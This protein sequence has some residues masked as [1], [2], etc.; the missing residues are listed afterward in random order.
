MM[1]VGIRKSAILLMS[2][3]EE[4]AGSVLRQLPHSAV[5]AM[6]E[7]MANLS[8]VKRDEV[9]AVLEEFRVETEQ[10]SALHLDSGSYLRAVLNKALGDDRA[11]DLLQDIAQSNASAGG[12][13]RLNQLDAKEVVEIIRDEHPQIIA[14]LLVHMDRLK[15]AEVLE[16]LP[17][18]VR[19]DAV[20]RVATFGGVQPSA[21]KELTEV[22]N[23]MLSGEGVK[24]G[25]LGG[26]RVAAEIV[27]LMTSTQEEGVIKHVREQD[28]VLAQKM[29]DEMFLFENLLELEDRSVQLLLKE[30]ESES[31]IIALKGAPV[32]L[33]EKFLKNM[34]QRA[35]ET[36]R[37]DIEARGPVRVSQVEAE[38]KSILL[39]VRRLADAGE[40]VLGGKGDDAYV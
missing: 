2:L 13:E 20:M 26:V 5:Q 17:D 21:L 6:S 24:R 15:A 18:R 8:Q 31:L 16:I 10:Y 7:A 34:S 3:G 28:A 37:E 22:L 4:G 35:A 38:Q 33:R 11:A 29:I 1:E 27:N 25:R 23:D 19:H 32:E 39:I 36:L 40:L 30:V 14:T 9:S 12:I